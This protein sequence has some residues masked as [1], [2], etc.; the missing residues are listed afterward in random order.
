[1]FLPGIGFT[2]GVLALFVVYCLLQISSN[3]AQGPYQ[4]FIP[5]LVPPGKR[6]LASGVKSL[7]EIMGGVA[8]IYPTALL[9]DRHFLLQ[10]TRWLWYALAAPGLVLLLGMLAS[11]FL[12]KESPAA[13]SLL[14]I[15]QSLKQTFRIDIR[16]Q[17]AFLWFLISRLLVFMAFVTI[18]QF[19]LNFLRDVIGVANPA[20]ATAHFS[21]IAVAGMLIIAWPAGNFSDKIGR[22]PII[23]ASG[24]LG[25]AS[26]AIIFFCQNY[27][28]ILWAAGILGMAIGAFNSTNWALATDLLPPKEE[29]RYLGLTNLAT[30]GGAALARLIGPVI[31]YLNHFDGTLGYQVMLL[32]CF[33]YFLAGALLVTRINQKP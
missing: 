14:S 22:K 19:A 24:M 33:S 3:T 15:R 7:L 17:R 32:V 26:I 11:I 27:T 1:L 20:T 8:L 29:A 10:E 9:M 13:G 31:D 16:K 21:I 25:A 28:S 23:I 5:D 4:A 18:Q 6:G 30:A 12:V 2:D